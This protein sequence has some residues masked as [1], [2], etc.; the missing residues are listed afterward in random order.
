MHARDK[1]SEH[2][3]HTGLLEQ[4]H[5]I[6]ILFEKVLTSQDLSDNTTSLTVPNYM[7]H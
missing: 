3:I 5:G 6:N 1:V 2:L 7:G 4:T